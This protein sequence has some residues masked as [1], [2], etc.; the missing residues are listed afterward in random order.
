[1]LTS[2]GLVV[3]VVLVVALVTILISN[4]PQKARFGNTSPVVLNEL[5]TVPLSVFNAVGVNS[6]MIQVAELVEAK[7]HPPL[8]VT[9]G[10]KTLPEALYVG[11]DYCP[12]CGATRW[13]IIVALSRFGTFNG[14]YDMFSSA[15]DVYPSTPTFSFDGTGPSD[16]VTYT[17]KYLVF[18]PYETL[19]RNSTPL[20][21]LP[22]AV[23]NLVVRYDTYQGQTG[24]IPFMDMNNHWLIQGSMFD[25]GTLAGHT[26]DSIAAGLTDPSNSVT[27][28]IIASANYV[29]AG[30][31]AMTHSQPASVCRSS[32]VLAAATAM[33]MTL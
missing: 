12:Y 33:Q 19:T 31:C 16:V 28:A 5:E 26:R 3:A 23:D 10:N 8:A 29:S 24:G 2:V 20:M 30:I 17:S 27:Q 32:G 22:P 25:P 13:G 14:L 11:A 7:G 9:V 6:P 15:T 1:M 4:G 21:T 18:T